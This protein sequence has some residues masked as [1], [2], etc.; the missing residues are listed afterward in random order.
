MKKPHHVFSVDPETGNTTKEWWLCK[1]C[2]S[3]KEEKLVVLEYK[4]NNDYGI[5][6]VE[7]AICL[8]CCAEQRKEKITGDL[9][10]PASDR[11]AL[12]NDA[13]P[14]DSGN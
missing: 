8:K 3:L 5:P 4:Y 6:L 11:L 10:E 1:V 12:I 7:A 13:I 14:T 2:D 9:I